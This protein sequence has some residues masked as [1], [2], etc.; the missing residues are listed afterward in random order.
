MDPKKFKQK[1]KKIAGTTNVDII[2]TEYLS[3]EYET[4]I[5]SKNTTT[6]TGLLEIIRLNPLKPD[7]PQFIFR[8]DENKDA[9][10]I[11][12]YKDR[13]RCNDLWGKNKYKGHHTRKISKE[14]KIFEADIN[15]PNG[16]IFKGIINV[17][18]FIQLA[19]KDSA[20]LTEEI[21]IVHKKV[22]IKDRCQA[23]EKAKT[24]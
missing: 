24:N 21:K 6:S 14:S 10:D 22:H 5:L 8:W 18:L 17:D 12:I 15:G 1:I 2:S 3:P 9:L 11:D 20:Q 16:I 23:E 4:E 19:L 13:K 7:L